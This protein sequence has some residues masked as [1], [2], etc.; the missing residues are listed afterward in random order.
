MNTASF[1]WWTRL[2]SRMSGGAVLVIA[3][4]VLLGWT[5]GSDLLKSI[6]PGWP[7]MSPLTA[8]GFVLAATSL[9]CLSFSR[10][11][12]RSR[13]LILWSRVCAGIVLLI[14]V[15][16]LVEYLVG[17]DLGIDPLGFHDAPGIGPPSMSVAT[18]ISFV[19]SAGA[20]LLASISRWSA[21]VQVF[22]LLGLLAGWLGLSRYLFGG[23]PLVPSSHMAVN[24]AS[25]FLFLITGVFCS[26]TDI[27]LMALLD[28]EHAGGMI[29]RFL[30]PPALAFPTVVGWAVLRGENAG[31]YGEEAG[32]SLF[33]MANVMIFGGL[34]WATADLLQ[35]TDL[36]RL[37]AE[38][39][40]NASQQ[41]LLAMADN[42]TAV[43]YV[44]DPQGRY[45]IVNRCFEDTFHVR[46]EDMVGKTDDDHFPR[47]SADSRRQIDQ[48]V[49]KE[50]RAIHVEE[51]A[52]L[53]DG[54][55][56]YLSV[57]YPLRDTR[58][59]FYAVCTISTDITDRKRAELKLETQLSRL[60]LLDEITRAIG[61]RQDLPSI[62]QVVIRTLEDS[63]SID[64]GCICLYDGAADVLTVSQIGIRS[65]EVAAALGISEKAV[66]P[67][68]ENGLSRC[69]RGE[70]V[71]V[72][73]ISQ[74]DRSFSRQLFHVG[75]LSVI[76]APLLS[77][78]NVCGVL[79][80]ARRQADG[81]ASDDCEFLRQLSEHVG[82]AAHQ[83]QIYSAL[84]HAYDDLRQTQQVVMQQERL[85]SLGQMASGVAHDINNAISPVALYTDLLLHSE[86]NL[87]QRV[88]QY[89]EITRRSMDDVAQTVARMR[90]FYRQEE[91][92]KTFAPVQLNQLVRQVLELT[93]VRWND[94]AHKHGVV[95]EERAILEQ[96]LPTI[97]GIESEIREALINF[98]FNAVDAMPEG[99]TLTIV[100]RVTKSESSVDTYAELEVIDSGIGMDEE[101]L[102]RCLEPFFTTKGERGTGLGLA[103]AYGMA[104]RHSADLEIES[105]PGAGAT[106][107]LRFPVP[108]APASG[109]M[110]PLDAGR[111][112][113]SQRILIID[114]D[115][116][117]IKSLFDT[118]V[119][120]GHTVVSANG[121]HE[122]I[123]VFQ[124]AAEKAEPFDLV[125]TDLGM[126]YVDGRK[127]ANAVKELSPSTPVI[128]LTGWG[129]RLMDDGDLPSHVDRILTKPAKLRDLRIALAELT[130][131][132][133]EV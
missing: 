118:L 117:I 99:G 5:I 20:L 17:Y 122:G 128:L 91:S 124:K 131:N 86:D 71:Y 89:L 64:F 116:L 76:A 57:K 50:G 95:I 93:R 29:A 10:S 107:R 70:L 68:D 72:S 45:L 78:S 52:I 85:R 18:A 98:V 100:T 90:D 22:I 48:Q 111:L 126:P 39:E 106:I 2:W 27:G 83:A 55:H 62:F 97:E 105:Q 40:V 36:E 23:I 13:P 61:E 104:Q 66:I 42:S 26:R 123:T 129:K 43:I 4:M 59:S 12:R 96:N 46:R 33:A 73:D 41:M 63:F 110:R 3:T 19:L 69:V 53:D 101:T 82:L 35:R 32:L 7:E 112:S 125:I 6:V 132:R 8:V 94:M 88:R 121:G 127:V 16:R 67:I 11:S 47:E 21:F 74:L 114:D 14:G 34:I 109:A 80:V 44:K 60:R 81:F 77:E 113:V 9:L 38:E 130:V 37:R 25:C 120:D 87:G 28:S 103:M 84:Q 56:T 92:Q 30:V 102:R 133:K 65:G 51:I 1:S 79:I 115:P 49:L 31:W 24:T 119:S 75:L 108:A 15:A 54:P 58:N